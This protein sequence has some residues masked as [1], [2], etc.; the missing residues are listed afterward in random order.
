MVDIIHSFNAYPS[1]Y[2]AI[3][4]RYQHW[5][6]KKANSSKLAF[7]LKLVQTILYFLGF[8]QIPSN[9]L[10]G[11]FRFLYTDKLLFQLLPLFFQMPI[12]SAA[13]KLLLLESCINLHTLHRLIKHLFS[14]CQVFFLF[15][16]LLVAA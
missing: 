7:F 16:F 2:R 12:L 3:L 10:F 4:A 14:V 1:L 6:T 8:F 15:V 13:L 9:Y 5:M 11:F